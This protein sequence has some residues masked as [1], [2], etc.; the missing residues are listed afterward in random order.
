[1]TTERCLVMQP[2]ILQ[3]WLSDEPI[4][5][6]LFAPAA[7]MTFTVPGYIVN[8]SPG[9]AVVD[10]SCD[11]K[12][13]LCSKLTTSA[14]CCVNNYRSHMI[15]LCVGTATTSGT[16]YLIE[17]INPRSLVFD[18]AYSGPLVCNGEPRVYIRTNIAPTSGGSRSKLRVL[19]EVKCD[20]RITAVASHPSAPYA[21]IG[22]WDDSLRVVS[23]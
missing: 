21:M 1:M 10:V 15:K 3:A 6:P 4:A 5:K 23:C 22:L 20:T 14:G 16:V 8:A 18:T 7:G 2:G 13:Y 19:S 11:L 12:E 17:K 9:S